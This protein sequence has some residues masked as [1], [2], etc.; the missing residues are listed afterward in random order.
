MYIK[1]YDLVTSVWKGEVRKGNRPGMS[2][3]MTAVES[4]NL[5]KG[6]QIVAQVPQMETTNG[7]K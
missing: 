1:I 3:M 2:L 6:V 5:Q 4:G 7:N